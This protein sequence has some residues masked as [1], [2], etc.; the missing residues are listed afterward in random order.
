[1]RLFGV[2]LLTCAGDDVKELSDLSEIV[3]EH[4][5][6]LTLVDADL[7]FSGPGM[8]SLQDQ[9]VNARLVLIGEQH[10]TKEIAQAA[11]IDIRRIGD[12]H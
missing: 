12:S 5:H 8:T 6:L 3:A 1:M 11:P 10:G 7:S 9:A 2:P 4:V